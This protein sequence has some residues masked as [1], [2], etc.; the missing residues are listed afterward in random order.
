MYGERTNL[1]GNKADEVI[2]LVLDY[3]HYLF[4]SHRVIKMLLASG[5]E[6]DRAGDESEESVIFA[7]ADVLAR[8]DVRATLAYDDGACLGRVARGNF[9]PKVFWIR[10]SSIFRCTG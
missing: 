5:S 3:V 4:D 8:E 10:I 2:L 6:L 1:N 9:H 7:H